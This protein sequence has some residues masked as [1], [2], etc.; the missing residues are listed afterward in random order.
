MYFVTSHGAPKITMNSTESDY[1]QRLKQASA[2]GDGNP[3]T[4]GI[5]NIKTPESPRIEPKQRSNQSTETNEID[6]NDLQRRLALYAKASGN[7]DLSNNN[8]SQTMRIN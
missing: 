7:A 3:F 5:Q 4:N 8:R 6:T 1:Q 2:Q